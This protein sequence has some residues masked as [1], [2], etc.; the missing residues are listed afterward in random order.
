MKEEMMRDQLYRKRQ[1][2]RDMT[3][4]AVTGI[5]L[6]LSG[7]AMGWIAHMVWGLNG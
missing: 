2:R 3:I 5:S 4:G 7:A 6:W 1:E